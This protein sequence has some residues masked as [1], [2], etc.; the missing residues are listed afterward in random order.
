MLGLIL[1]SIPALSCW[2][3]SPCAPLPACTSSAVLMWPT[4]A[5]RYVWLKASALTILETKRIKGALLPPS[6]LLLDP[7]RGSRH[8]FF[9]CLATPQSAT[10][11]N[12][13]VEAAPAIRPP[14]TFTFP[15]SQCPPCLPRLIGLPAPAGQ[16]NTRVPGKTPLPA[17]CDL[18]FEHRAAGADPHQPR[19]HATR[20]VHRLHAVLRQQAAS[21]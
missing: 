13:Y 10:E 12:S 2:F 1:P 3:R 14:S 17:P 18:R 9:A 15:P 16:C 4:T 7:P 5:T 19:Q 11:P 21:V 20:R 6:L 8:L